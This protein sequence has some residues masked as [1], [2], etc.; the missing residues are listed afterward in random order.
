VHNL[1]RFST[2]YETK[3]AKIYTE[4]KKKSKYKYGN[5]ICKYICIYVLNIPTYITI[6]GTFL[7]NNNKLKNKNII[8]H[9]LTSPGISDRGEGRVD[10]RAEGECGHPRPP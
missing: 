8:V 10:A 2:I 9:Y 1:I 6:L 7:S 4:Y 5:Y 3:V